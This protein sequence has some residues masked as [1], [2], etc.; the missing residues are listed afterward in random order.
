MLKANGKERSYVDS[1]IELCY[2]IKYC[3]V[4][5]EKYL[6]LRKKIL[7]CVYV[8]VF[9]FCRTNLNTR[10]MFTGFTM[11]ERLNNAKGMEVNT[12]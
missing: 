11:T 8:W 9:L 1:A 6:T 5:Y 4:L 10:E 7:G 2:E 3:V 12:V